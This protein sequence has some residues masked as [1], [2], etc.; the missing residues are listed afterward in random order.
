[1]KILERFSDGGLIRL[2]EEEMA[3]FE[4]LYG[5]GEEGDADVD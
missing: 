5:E 2:N 1:M 4:I 3:A